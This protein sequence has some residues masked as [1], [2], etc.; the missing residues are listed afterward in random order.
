MY[1][2]HVSH[3]DNSREI[4]DTLQLTHEGTTLVKRVRINTL[5]HDYKLVRIKSE[6][7][8]HVIEKHCI[9]SVNHMRTLGKD[10][11]NEYLV[12]K[13]ISFLYCSLKPK[14]ATTYES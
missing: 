11:Q 4:W 10:F 7:N 9:H 1:F 14:V 13:V 2:L 12:I 6:R 5:T 8:I 3:Y